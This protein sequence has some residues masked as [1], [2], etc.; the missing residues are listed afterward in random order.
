LGTEDEWEA[1]VLA[2][3]ESEWKCLEVLAVKQETLNLG[4]CFDL[5]ACPADDVLLLLPVGRNLIF[6]APFTMARTI[7]YMTKSIISYCKN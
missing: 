2:V 4:G 7:K 6:S 5:N 1:Y 3:K